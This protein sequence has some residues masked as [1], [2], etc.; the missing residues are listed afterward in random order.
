[1]I[2]LEIII[3]YDQQDCERN[4]MD[5]LNNIGD[6][7][8]FKPLLKRASTPVN[9]SDS[10]KVSKTFTSI[11]I[12]FITHPFSLIIFPVSVFFVEN[13]DGMCFGALLDN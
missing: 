7:I 3:N 10:G 12:F 5:E 6:G 4:D 1:M 8:L 9:V 2:L 11:L 13:E